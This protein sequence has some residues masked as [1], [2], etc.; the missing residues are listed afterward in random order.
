MR[1]VVDLTQQQAEALQRLIQAGKYPSVAQFI[2]AAVE[3]QIHIEN[4]IDAVPY[5]GLAQKSPIAINNQNGYAASANLNV[6][7]KVL[8]VKPQSVNPPKFSDLVASAFNIPEDKSWLWGQTN[9]ILPM[10]IGLRYLYFYLG[11][12]Q[13][14]ELEGFRDKAAEVAAE[15]GTL[16][17]K[18]EN[19]KNKKRDDKISAGLPDIE[20]FKSK[21]RYKS[22]FLG[23]MR[24]DG[25]MDGAMPFLRFANL[26]RD[27]KGVVFIG[28]TKAGMQF[29]KLDNPPVAGDYNIS[30]SD[31]EVDFYLE[32][33][34]ESVPGEY[35][36]IIWLLRKLDGGVVERRKLNLEIKKEF[37]HIWKDA[38]DAVINTQRAGLMARMFELGLI[39]KTKEGIAVTY[40]V[41]GRGK[42][43]LNKSK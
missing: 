7:L 26:R 5:S 33:I 18:Y 31:K 20:E 38:T 24:K 1:Y 41:S 13:W 39:E 12:G 16:V 10:K 2:S 19:D 25:L 40:G 28:M 43:F 17:K 42:K 9:K 30:F 6:S 15:V 34:S 4:N 35:N 36:A 21:Q 11:D 8:S 27:D 14:T 3:N 37:G 23:Y 22:H 29:A 32:H